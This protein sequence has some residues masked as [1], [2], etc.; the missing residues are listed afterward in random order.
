MQEKK[1]EKLPPWI[2]L[3]ES[4]EF[5]QQAIDP[6]THIH[7]LYFRRP[8][9]NTLIRL[10]PRGEYAIDDRWMDQDG[11][12][13][14]FDQPKQLLSHIEWLTSD[15]KARLYDN[16]RFT[17]DNSPGRDA[18]EL[19]KMNEAFDRAM[20]ES[21]ANY[22]DDPEGWRGM[23]PKEREDMVARDVMNG[24]EHEEEE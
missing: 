12:M 17:A 4:K 13:L 1:I 7:F 23:N 22:N 3:L 18:G 9:I 8:M 11:N 14:R 5:K 16:P 2:E 19:A 21:F 24:F 10:H 20:F 15:C 6:S